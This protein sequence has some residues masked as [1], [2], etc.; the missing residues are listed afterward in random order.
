MFPLCNSPSCSITALKNSNKIFVTIFLWEINGSVFALEEKL[1][2]VFVD[3][4]LQNVL[5]DSYSQPTKRQTK[6]HT[7]LQTWHVQDECHECHLSNGKIIQSDRFPSV[8]ADLWISHFYFMI[9]PWRG[10]H[11]VWPSWLFFFNDYSDAVPVCPVS[12]TVYIL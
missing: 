9:F 12:N 5:S 2:H 7:K 8:I 3:T 10:P 1:P 6:W 4:D 11:A